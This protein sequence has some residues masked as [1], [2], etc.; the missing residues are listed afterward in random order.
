M[1]SST[2]ALSGLKH[3][4]LSAE[5]R[6]P[7]PILKLRKG[8]EEAIAALRAHPFFGP[9]GPRRQEVLFIGDLLRAGGGMGEMVTAEEA[10]R[11]RVVAMRTASRAGKL[12]RDAWELQLSTLIVEGH[13]RRGHLLNAIGAESLREVGF[14]AAELLST[15]FTLASLRDG[16]FTADG[17]RVAGLRAMELSQAGFTAGELKSGGFNAKARR[18]RGLRS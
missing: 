11:E 18:A 9:S 12:T 6:Y 2:A 5:S 15:G 17:L 14:S 4:I 13:L 8:G 10:S 3:L 1:A 16:G 7:I